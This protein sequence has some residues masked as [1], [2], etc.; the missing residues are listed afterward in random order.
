MRVFDFDNT[1]YDGESGVDLFLYFLK[2][3]TKG[4]MKYAP[5]FFEGFLK[6]KKAKITV[7]EMMED[8]SFILK[9]YSQQIDDIYGEF[10]KFWDLNEENVKNFYRHIQKDDDVIVSACP[11]CLLKIIC[12]RIG[13]KNYIGSDINP[14]TGEMKNICYKDNKVKAYR[15]VYGDTP[16]DE[17]F[18]DSISDVAMIEISDNVFWVDGETITQIK[19]DG[20]YTD[21]AEEIMNK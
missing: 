13:I 20:K 4:L 18:T 8:Y 3:D 15:D 14:L 7:D 1:I 9:E 12:D 10:E 19:K 6:Y 5:K 21:N 11:V 16:I 2:K 17:F